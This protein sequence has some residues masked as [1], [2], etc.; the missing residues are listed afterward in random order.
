[1][2]STTAATAAVTTGDK[3]KP[4]YRRK[5]NSA[6]YFI[7]VFHRKPL[8]EKT[9]YSA[10]MVKARLIATYYH[11]MV[12]KS[13]SLKTVP[14]FFFSNANTSQPKGA[15]RAR[16]RWAETFGIPRRRR[17]ARNGNEGKDNKSRPA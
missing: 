3:R 7:Y 1:V 15:L 17:P 16:R 9:N 12:I 5:D 14:G 11:K 4:Y 6:E 13:I 2:V 8:F 10:R